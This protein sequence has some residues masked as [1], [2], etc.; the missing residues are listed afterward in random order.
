[1]VN[2]ACNYALGLKLVFTYVASLTCNVDNG[3]RNDRCYSHC[4]ES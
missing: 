1:M 4:V 2:S 3:E